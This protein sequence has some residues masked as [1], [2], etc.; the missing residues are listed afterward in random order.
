[1]DKKRKAPDTKHK[2]KKA[3]HDDRMVV[4]KSVD[5]T[6]FKTVTCQMYIHVPP[7]YV[8]KTIDGVND[9]L[10]GFLMK[11]SSTLDGIVLSH[12]NLV[13]PQPKARIINDSPFAHFWITVD[14]LVWKPKRGSRLVGTV[15]LQS[16][17][18][19]GLLIYGTFNAS[20]PREY[21]PS[22][23]E[24]NPSSMTTTN[25]ASLADVDGET[26][27]EDTTTEET[28]PSQSED[29][30]AT[31]TTPQN[32]EW[33]SK[34]SGE[35]I[36]A[37]EGVLDF[38]VVD[39]VHANDMLSAA[40]FVG[41]FIEYPFDTVKVRL[42]TESGPGAYAG[43]LDCI[44]QTIQQEGVR[45]LYKGL[46]SPLI[47]SVMEAA[48]LFVGYKHVQD[49]IRQATWTP[50]EKQRYSHIKKEDDLPP[51][52]IQQLVLAGSMSGAFC[53]L[54]LTPVE[55]V[56][57]KLQ[58]QKE[59]L[60]TEV[61]PNARATIVYKGPLHVV[62]HVMKA[63]GLLGFY[64]GHLAT[65]I[66]ETAGGAF[67]FGIY[68]LA[69]LQFV[70]R[71]QKQVGS[72]RTITKADLAPW[73]LM[74][75]GALGGMCYNFSIFPVDV[76][77]SHMQ[78]EQE[79]PYGNRVTKRPFFQVAR[80]IYRDTGIKGFYRGCGI[81]VARSAPSNAIIFMTYELLKRQFG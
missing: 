73:Q 20:I 64:R 61:V 54:I 53:S 57:C 11:Y 7:I 6:P 37:K 12:S 45:G 52:S 23:F 49:M 62:S 46:T 65:F 26:E 5:K 48:A 78:T 67:W 10:N 22:D 43:P 74:S 30:T 31:R 24:W 1:M 38:L 44:K 76:I 71:K 59:P 70:K 34:S 58:V 32:G 15:N 33:I 36:G 25:N 69:C 47:G 68:E 81:T 4:R 8:G 28:E 75:A 14:F 9:Q 77:K 41:K 51:L 79:H 40:G 2:R 50:E 17:D 80:D 29:A 18:H 42:Q 39:L 27:A 63:E 35:T 3:K 21:I 55:L 13:I 19:I 72:T 66:R 16:A 60:V 56:K